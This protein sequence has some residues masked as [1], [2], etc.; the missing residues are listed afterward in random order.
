MINSAKSDENEPQPFNGSAFGELGVAQAMPLTGWAFTY[1]INP[2]VVSSTIVSTGVISNDKGH[3]VLNTGTASDGKAK[4][5][6]IR[7]TRYI[8][9]VGGYSRFV[10]VFGTPQENNQQVIGLINGADG[11]AFGYN[12]L[13]F[14][15]IRKVNGVENWI[16]QEDW[17]IDIKPNLDTSKGNIF[18][19]K[20]QWL[21]YGMQYFYIEDTNGNLELV[22]RIRYSNKFTETSIL[23]PN[24][25]L[26]AYVV[27]TGNVVPVELKTSSAIAGLE[28]DGFNDAVSVSVGGDV[29]YTAPSALVNIPLISFRM[30][31]IYKL[32]SNRL[33]CQ[34][35]R[36]IFACEGNKPVLFR[37]FSGGTVTGGTWTYLEEELS[38][39]EVNNTIT[40]YTPGIRLG[41]FPLGKSGTLE[42]DLVASNF[43]LYSNQI[44]TITATTQG[45]SDVV[46]SANWKSFV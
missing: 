10:G 30:A 43:R 31:D 27:N 42:S 12:G 33:F 45:A 14:G 11:W 15:I 22:H 40:S 16:Y 46:V 34:L 20:Y 9:G 21:G 32:K 38:P 28:G 35:L 24:L 4:I 8:P 13:K 41:A 25:P 1:N 2:G 37:A 36:L 5:E 29:V 6:T 3:A 17:N 19:I 26:S 18:Q 39:L 23:N 44:I 7:S